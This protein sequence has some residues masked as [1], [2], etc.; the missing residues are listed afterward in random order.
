MPR[1]PLVRADRMQNIARRWEGGVM[2]HP[3]GD[4]RRFGEARRRYVFR[5]GADRHEHGGP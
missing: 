5:D 1:K 3:T 2:R 4:E